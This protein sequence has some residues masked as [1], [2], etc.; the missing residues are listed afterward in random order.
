MKFIN[1]KHINA[2][3]MAFLLTALLIC[4]A[5]ATP[6]D[7]HGKGNGNGKGRGRGHGNSGQHSNQRKKDDKFVNG[8]DARDGR[9]DGR[10]PKHKH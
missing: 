6:L 5:T 1:S 8:H 3:A 7:K 10:G 9:L 4:T 2:W